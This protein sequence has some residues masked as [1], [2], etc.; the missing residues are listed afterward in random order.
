MILQELV[1]YYDRKALD[2]DL[3]QRLPQFGLEDKEIPFIIE[4]LPDGRVNQLRDTRVLDGKKLRAQS[5]LVPQ[6]E[7]KASGVKA[8]LLWDSA[9]YAIGLARERKSKA[10]I[11]AWVANPAKMKPDTKMPTLPLT[12]AQLEEIAEFLSS[13]AN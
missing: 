2:P 4:L 10:E 13:L 8:N 12:P 3:A 6:G 11:I 5:F 9:S 7:K 1:C